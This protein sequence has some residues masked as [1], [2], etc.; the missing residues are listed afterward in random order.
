MRIQFDD[1]S[2]WYVDGDTL[3]TGITIEELKARLIPWPLH[4]A[5]QR[6]QALQDQRALADVSDA[7]LLAWARQAHPTA[8][9]ATLLDQQMDEQRAI[10]AEYGA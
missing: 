10:I 5:R 3:P 1:G 6:L 8:A 2:A 9:T 4:E 7:D